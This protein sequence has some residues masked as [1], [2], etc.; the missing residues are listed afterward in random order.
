MVVTL[1]TK[2]INS[3]AAIVHELGLLCIF[4]FIKQREDL[5]GR[6]GS[7]KGTHILISEFRA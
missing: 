3:S 7:M 5:S 2:Q 6:H 1:A 4:G